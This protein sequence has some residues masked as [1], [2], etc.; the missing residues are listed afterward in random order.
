MCRQCPGGKEKKSEI[1]QF[2][3]CL[4]CLFLCWCHYF[5]SLILPIATSFPFFQCCIG[6]TSVQEGLQTKSGISRWTDSVDQL[7]ESQCHR[8]GKQS[9]K[10]KVHLKLNFL[11][12]LCDLNQISTRKI[13]TIVTFQGEGSYSITVP[14]PEEGHFTAF[15]IEV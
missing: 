9:D 2:S 14:Q 7:Q 12:F 8:L 4:F 6:L 15:F 13:Q 1:G 10:D 11:H 5:C 3:F